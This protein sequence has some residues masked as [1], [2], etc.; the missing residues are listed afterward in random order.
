[1]LAGFLALSAISALMIA[2]TSLIAYEILR[3][4]WNLLP[5]LTLP[6][7][8]RVVLI[9]LPIFAAHI[10]SIW[11]YA[12]AYFLI[13]NYTHF[14]VLTGLIG[15]A[16]LSYESFVERLYFSSVTYTS[17]GFGDVIPTRDLRM[18]ASAEVLN[19]L[20]MIG[21][22]VSFTYLTMEKFW[23]LPHRKTKKRE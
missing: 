20:V 18:L 21:W 9:I 4:V 1:M 14:G 15:P 19:G 16:A 22:T 13:E 6:P 8:L 7:R 17:L 11:L 2:L 23:P 3:H 5:R 10:L 12:L